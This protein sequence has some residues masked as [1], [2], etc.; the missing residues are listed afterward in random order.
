MSVQVYTKEQ[1]GKGNFDN[2]RIREYKPIGFPIDQSELK[3]YSNIFYWAYAWSDK[4]GLI[5]RHPHKGFEIL[6]FVLDGEIEHYDNKLNGWKKLKKGDV[7][8]IRSGDGIIHAERLLPN[9]AM[10][11]I[12]IDP[13]VSKTFYQPAS[14]NDYKLEAFRIVEHTTYSEKIIRDG[15]TDFK[16]DSE[17][18]RIKEYKLKSDTVL[19]LDFKSIYSCYLISGALSI[20]DQKINEGDF[21]VINEIESVSISVVSESVLFVLESPSKV[22]YKTYAETH[23]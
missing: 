21:V 19:K 13:N 10:F 11:Q 5:D 7:Q 6:S 18:I 2:G 1:Q 17:G 12:W 9:S 8:I 20:G 23:L 15:N 14:Y 22:S 4:G 3:P 16:M